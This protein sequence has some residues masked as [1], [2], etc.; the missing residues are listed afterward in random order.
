MKFRQLGKTGPRV[1]AIDEQRARPHIDGELMLAGEVM[2]EAV[3]QQLFDA[4]LAIALG[5]ERCGQGVRVD[6]VGGHK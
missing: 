4:R 3:Q 5:V 6:R 2:I 1:S